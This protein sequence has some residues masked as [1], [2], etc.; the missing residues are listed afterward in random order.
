LFP[1]PHLEH[2]TPIDWTVF[3]DTYQDQI[4][5]TV[6]RRLVPGLR[7][8]VELVETITPAEWRADGLPV[9]TP[10]GAA[11]SLPQTGPFR[12]PTRSRRH[13][14]VVFCGTNTQPG[15]GV[16]MVLLSGRL[17]AARIMGRR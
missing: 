8:R 14:N 2:P 17:A 13:D 16:P 5:D 4:L 10:F 9:G 15:V 12:P 1:V 7:D 3:R 11:H 6:Q